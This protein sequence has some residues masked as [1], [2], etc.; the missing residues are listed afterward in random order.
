ME[1][2]S[3]PCKSQYDVTRSQQPST[4]ISTPARPCWL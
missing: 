2:D 1:G 3:M 4:T